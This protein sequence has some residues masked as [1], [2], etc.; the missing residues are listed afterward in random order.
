MAQPHEKE[1]NVIR[2]FGRRRRGEQKEQLR[3]LILREA[4]E[5]FIEQGYSAFSMRKLA[6]QIG[7]APATL[8]QYFRDKDHLLFSVVDDA[9]TRFRTELVQAANST[10]DPWEC[11]DRIGETYVRFGLTHSAYYQL[12]FMW[13]VDYLIQSQ[14]GEQTP[15]MEAF[16]VLVDAVRNAQRQGVIKPGDVQ[17]Y[18]DMLWATMHGVVALAIQIPLFTTERT[19]KLVAHAKEMLYLALRP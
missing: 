15:R 10:T 12:M 13:R 4:S 6:K 5:L 17:A 11:L 14:Y 9:F 8:Y 16:Q 1:N 3:Q 18:S 19:A 7:Y 2:K